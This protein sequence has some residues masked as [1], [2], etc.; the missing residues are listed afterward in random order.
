MVIWQIFLVVL[1]AVIVGGLVLKFGVINTLK[2]LSIIPI[3]IFSIILDILLLPITVFKL[4]KSDA[5]LQKKIVRIYDKVFFEVSS[6]K[7]LR[8]NMKRIHLFEIKLNL[9][10]QKKKEKEISKILKEARWLL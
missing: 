2:V 5:N 3:I 9:S 8:N 1:L 10:K 6:S 7:K 4:L